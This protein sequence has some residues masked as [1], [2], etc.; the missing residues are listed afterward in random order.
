MPNVYFSLSSEVAP[1]LGEYER[2]ATAL[3]NAYVGPVIEN[4][5]DGLVDQLGKSGLKRQPL[6]AQAN[7]GL[8]TPSQTIPIFTVESGPAAGVVGSAHVAEQL[9]VSNV[10]A[11]DVGGTTFKVSIIEGGKWSYSKETILNQ[12]QLRLP[13]IDVVSIGAGG[14]SI[15]WVDAGGA[16]RVGPES[17]GAVP[18]P[19]C[20]G[21]GGERPTV[22]DANLVLGYMDPD[23]FLGG[24]MA[25]DRNAAETAIEAHVAEPLGISTIEAAVGISRIA[26]NAMSNA[27]RYVSV[28]RGRDPRDYALMAFGGAGALSAGVQAADVGIKS[29][30]VPRSASVLSALGG[31]MSDFKVSK[32]QSF[33]V[34]ADAVELDALNDVFLRMHAEAERALQDA[35][36]VSEVVVNRFL[37][38][39]YPGQV[40]EVIVPLR[41]RT[42]RVTAVN[43]AR[44]V[45]DFHDLHE[46]LYAFKRPDQGA[47]I[48]SLRLELTGL[49]ERLPLPAKPFEGESADH[50]KLGERQVYFE[51][52]GFVDCP[53]YEGPS[54]RP[55]NLISGPA[56]IHEPDTTIV[57]YQSQEAMLDPHDMYV[58]EVVD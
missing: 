3:F 43:L 28:S 35:G 29:I 20:Y 13:M 8:A 42:R 33:V 14:G 55:G 25:L 7:G 47:E 4:Y 22:T 36:A 41:S 1:V 15:A 9:G 30:L 32:I 24:A 17:A 21:R 5:L 11:T 39:H 48:V 6:I 58:I 38:I 10:I 34:A 56:V 51:G 26:N 46:Q 52:L 27:I 40:Q 23:R 45:R 57:V 44:A 49:R 37:D 31:L 53:I 50:A 12:Y 54:L 16:L 2:S 19:A 18:G